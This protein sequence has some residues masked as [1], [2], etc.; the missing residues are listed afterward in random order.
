MF[1]APP[2]DHARI[3]VSKY[4]K[5]NNGMKSVNRSTTGHKCCRLENNALTIQR[6]MPY[7]GYISNW[8]I[9]K[10]NHNK[11]KNAHI[12]NNEFTKWCRPKLHFMICSLR[13]TVSC[14]YSYAYKNLVH[15]AYYAY[16]NLVHVCT[17]ISIALKMPT[18][19]SKDKQEVFILHLN[20]TALGHKKKKKTRET[21]HG[22]SYFV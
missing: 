19:K 16:K 21:D 17:P 7:M 4:N 18:I 13:H 2:R 22:I 3:K 5:S 1:N 12:I 11:D 14:I 8:T 6:N 9:Q 15:V 10:Y 20:R